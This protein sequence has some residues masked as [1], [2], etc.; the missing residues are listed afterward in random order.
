M[1]GKRLREQCP[2][3]ENN[4]VRIAIVGTGIAGLAS[5]WLLNRRHAI[6]V[7][8]AEPRLGGHTNTV[9]MTAGDREIAVDTGFIVYNE[10]TYPLLTKLFAHLDVRT[11]ASDM[12]FSASIGEG[13]LE[14][15]GS[16]MAALFA[17]RRN[18]LRP[19]FLRMLVDIGRFNRLGWRHL[20]EEADLE[21]TV[22][23]FLAR[24]GFGKGLAEWYLLPMAAAIWSAPV[25][26]MLDYP[27]RSFLAFFANHGLLSVGAHRTWRTVAGGS[28]AYVERML[29]EFRP[30]V[31]LATPIVGVRRW[32]WG[33]ELL[34]DRGER[35][36]FDQVVLACTPT[37]ASPCS[38]TRATRNARS[39]ERSAT[40]PTAPSCIATRR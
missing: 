36:R 11:E 38:R 32:P 8:E 5:A 23:Q 28:R 25:A 15:A 27:A 13:A 7:F 35:Y 14:Y 26:R 39:W 22:G 1:V 17:Q 21:L 16:S 3:A 4:H 31:R 40:S 34:D 20:R 33:V 6:T 12:S 37:R 24:H 29:P 9:T 10:H 19:S 30:R 18:A 2:L